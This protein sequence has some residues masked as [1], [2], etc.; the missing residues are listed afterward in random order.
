M[1]CVCINDMFVY[2]LPLKKLESHTSS[3]S[4]AWIFFKLPYPE[5]EK[6]DKNV[7]PSRSE[8]RKNSD[9]LINSTD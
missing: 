9:P 5:E 8:R 6:Y 2:N 4:P 7:A 1:T 3:S